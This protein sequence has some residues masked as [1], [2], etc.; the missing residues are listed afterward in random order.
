LPAYDNLL[1]EVSRET[2][3]LLKNT[4]LETKAVFYI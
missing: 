1:I 2:H 3:L 4:A